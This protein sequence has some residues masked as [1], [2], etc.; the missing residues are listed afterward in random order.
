[1]RLL[2]VGILVLLGT[3]SSALGRAQQSAPM[4]KASIK[5]PDSYELRANFRPEKR[6]K[7]LAEIREHLWAHWR[8]H[9][10]AQLTVSEY[11]TGRESHTTYAIK[12]DADGIWQLNIDSKSV[13]TDPWYPDKKYNEQSAY[14]V[15]TVER[16]SNAD[17]NADS[18]VRLPADAQ[19]SSDSYHLVLLDK[20]G[21][22]VQN[23]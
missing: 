16:V 7:T 14:H 3:T 22:I 1:M 4:Q 20:A 17:N 19:L 8:Q 6:L 12:A 5:E 10:P 13:V 2:T 15:Y 23:L 18:Q 21:K 9:Q 11:E